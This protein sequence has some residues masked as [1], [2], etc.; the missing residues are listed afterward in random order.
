MPFL[1]SRSQL[2]SWSPWRITPQVEKINLC[3]STRH[4]ISWVWRVSSEIP[5]KQYPSVLEETSLWWPCI[6]N[7]CIFKKKKS[8]NMDASSSAYS[9]R[10]SAVLAHRCCASQATVKLYEVVPVVTSL[11]QTKG[12]FLYPMRKESKFR[13]SLSMMGAWPWQS[14]TIAWPSYICSSHGLVLIMIKNLK[15][16][17]TT[18]PSLVL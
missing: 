9:I 11:N 4:R 3:N 13:P 5:V 2:L 10:F 8:A 7:N 12:S 18:P 6:K 16:N 1:F 15:K 17:T 14:M